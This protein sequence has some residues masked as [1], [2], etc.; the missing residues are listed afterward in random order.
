MSSGKGDE[1]YQLQPQNHT[2]TKTIADLIS[3]LSLSF[4]KGTD[5]YCL[6]GNSLHDR[7]ILYLPEK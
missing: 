5:D 7:F 3:S 2:V 6:Q 1:K 4:S